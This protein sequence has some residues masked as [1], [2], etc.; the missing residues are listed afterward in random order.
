[1]KFDDKIY[2]MGIL[3]VSEDSF[4]D[5]NKYFEKNKALERAI[6]II[7][8]GADI[9]D[10]GGESTKPNS[11]KISSDEE[12]RRILDVVVEI[13]KFKNVIISIDTYKSQ[14]ARECLKVGANI[15]ND[16]YGGLY[17]EKIFS[18]VSEYNSH[19]CITHNRMFSKNKFSN[20]VD[21]TFE[22]LKERYERALSF[23]INPDKMIL[24]PGLGFSKYGRN[25]ILI[26]KNIS[27]FK[28]LG[29]PILVGASRKKFLRELDGVD[30]LE[31]SFSTISVTA[32]LASKGVNIL[33]VHDVLE[34]KKVV[35]IINSIS[36]G[37]EAADE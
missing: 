16:V 36:F 31:N 15:I 18:V 12:I 25:N 20:V 13:R 1:M 7:E 19:I 32:Y 28:E 3:N 30:P 27:K 11:I 26:L 2:L 37:G 34:N 9:I 29:V 6:E 21:E 35:D 4:Y 23:N 24:D 22:E 5:G 17:D 33:R 10:I 14:V 8:N